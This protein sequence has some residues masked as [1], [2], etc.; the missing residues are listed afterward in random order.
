ME[1][2]LLIFSSILLIT[3]LPIALYKRKQRKQKEMLLLYR[4][5]ER[6]RHLQNSI[7]KTIVRPS[8]RNNANSSWSKQD[9]QAKEAWDKINGRNI[10]RNLQ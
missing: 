9:E 3:T 2:T 4:E 6:R 10:Q 5:M 8:I 1:S 7:Q